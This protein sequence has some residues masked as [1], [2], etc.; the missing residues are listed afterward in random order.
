[1]DAKAWS[2][3]ELQGRHLKLETEQGQG[4]SYKIK[5]ERS[6]LETLLL[7]ITS[8][9]VKHFFFRTAVIASSVHR[10][11]IDMFWRAV[12]VWMIFSRA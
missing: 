8:D 12:S 5:M 3:A 11:R 2:S 4:I 7:P 10:I 6:D 9:L 1:M